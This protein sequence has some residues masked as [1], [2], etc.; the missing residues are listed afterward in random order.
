M[1]YAIQYWREY[2][3]DNANI[4]LRLQGIVTKHK[5]ERMLEYDSNRLFR[6]LHKDWT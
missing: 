4:C 3:T 1:W 5:S 6:R 2:V